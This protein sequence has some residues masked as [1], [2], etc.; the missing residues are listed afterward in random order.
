MR[1]GAKNVIGRLGTAMVLSVGLAGCSTSGTVGAAGK[2][3]G[4]A[5]ASSASIAG[6]QPGK[7]QS[8]AAATV[9]P[10][11]TPTPEPDTT[12]TKDEAAKVL[13]DY[14]A[15]NNAAN[16]SADT[17]AIAK[18]ESG[19]LLANDQ[20]SYLYA[21]GAGGDRLKQIKQPFSLT[22]PTFY[23]SRSTAY[24]R[25]FFAT[26]Q[27]V[28]S[29]TANTS[30]LLHFV[31]GATGA[32][33]LA[34]SQVV[35]T[36]GKQW[37]EFAVGADGL[38]DD[39]AVQRDK[40]AMNPLDLVSADRTML[41]DDNAGQPASPFLNDEVTASEQRWIHSEGDS[42]AP[43][44]VALTVTTDLEPTPLT[45]PL[46]SGGE[47]VVWGSRLSL[48]ISQPGHTFPFTDQGWAKLAGRDSFSDGFTVDAV[49]SAA[50]VDPAD[51][52]AKI[53]KLAQSGGVVALR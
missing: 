28:Q 47:L 32:P 1:H 14:E 13:K 23:I 8:S 27:S 33:W 5:K 24:P 2:P 45:L 11:P 25:G 35:L 40:L 3:S 48:R 52:A 21:L 4:A 37:P 17:A 50:A 15:A 34:D 6:G 42:V 18:L 20:A 43:A 7:T 31:Q 51:K 26:V 38:L 9:P 49:F 39:N 19:A 53:E 41:A 29:G 46:K 12:V 16:A 22:N 10:P 44:T 30:W 36:S